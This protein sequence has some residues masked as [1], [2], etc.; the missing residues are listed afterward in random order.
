MDE[1]VLTQ[2]WSIGG[3]YPGSILSV[4]G[5]RPQG[6]SYSHNKYEGDSST[7][8]VGAS[9]PLCY[10]TRLQTQSDGYINNG[11]AHSLILSKFQHL[12]NLGD[13]YTLDSLRE[14]NLYNQQISESTNQY[15]FS[16]PFSGVLVAPAAHNFIINFMSNHSA[17]QLDG[18]LDESQ[19]KI[20]FG[21]SGPDN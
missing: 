21:I 2:T 10:C 6:I 9:H 16:A 1:V 19:L 15:Y 7:C 3:P 13:T 12:Y 20:F 4:L 5:G 14:Q 11:N 8:R 18:Y 17:D